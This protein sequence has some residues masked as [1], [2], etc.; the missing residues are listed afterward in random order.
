MIGSTIFLQNKKAS[1]APKLNLVALMDIFTIL[2]FFL[3]L[4]SG[5]SQKI[6]NAKFIELPDSISG[7]TPHNQLLIL[8]NDDQIWIGNEAVANVTD[9]LKAPGKPIDSLTAALAAHKE[10]LGEL[11]DYEKHNGLPVTI[12]GNKETSYILLKSVM[13]TCQHSDFREIS[14]AVNQVIP[15][16]PKNAGAAGNTVA[17]ISGKTGG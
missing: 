12:L 15:N 11:S 7:V 3:L 14:L 5:E 8:I 1:I 10:S 4:N 2:V 16:A 9:I 13:A 6:E 17:S